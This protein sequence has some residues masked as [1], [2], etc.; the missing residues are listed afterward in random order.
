MSGWVVHTL[1]A[2]K[3]AQSMEQSKGHQRQPQRQTGQQKQ[4][5][6]H[7]WKADEAQR[8]QT[9]GAAEQVQS[10]GQRNEQQQHPQ[11]QTRQQQQQHDH[12]RKADETQRQQQQWVLK[13]Q[14]QG[15]QQEVAV[16]GR[17]QG[18]E[19]A[20]N[21]E[22]RQEIIPRGYLERFEEHVGPAQ[23]QQIMDLSVQHKDPELTDVVH[24]WTL[25]GFKDAGAR[26]MVQDAHDR[27]KEQGACY[28]NSTSSR[29]TQDDHDHKTTLKANTFRAG[30]DWA[31]GT[32]GLGGGL[33]P[34]VRLARS[35]P[36]PTL[37]LEL[38]H[39]ML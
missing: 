33:H 11:R 14:R 24:Y 31:D 13:Q 32:G 26:Q 34:F 4:Q 18:T 19:Q 21:A 22:T 23:W 10:M 35:H 36:S 27:N 1:G 9:L 8:Q 25:S 38:H 16:V 6:D 20:R 2:A 7:T 17:A 37:A 28:K 15:K 30:D 3:Q 5:Q 39:F 29:M 12:R